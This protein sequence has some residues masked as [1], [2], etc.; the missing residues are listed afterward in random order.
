M[1]TATSTCRKYM[2]IEGMTKRIVQAKIKRALQALFVK[3]MKLFESGVGERAIAARLAV[4]LAEE[5][6][7]WHVDPEYDRV[8]HEGE[9]EP[10]KYKPQRGQKHRAIPDIIVHKR[11]QPVNLL[12]IELKKAKNT[13]DRD[14]DFEK[15][16]A[17][18]TQLGYSFAVF[19]EVGIR[20]DR[21]TYS[22]RFF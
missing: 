4:H 16:K 18:R 7:N 5:F 12:A 19:L 15:L 6:P 11:Q 9:P 22:I 17:Y 3:D 14:K 2:I 20:E 8:H 13:R 10:K 1:A 21:P